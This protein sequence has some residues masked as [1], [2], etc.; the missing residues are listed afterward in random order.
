VA[1][2]LENEEAVRNHLS[3]FRHELS[4]RL[5]RIY[6]GF[7]QLKKEGYHVDA[8]AP[9][10]AI[11]LTVQIDLTGK[12]TD[13]GRLLETQADVTDYILNEAKLALVP[14]NAF[15]AGERSCW[16]RLS[17]GCCKKEDIDPMLGKLKEALER[18]T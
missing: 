15:G 17:V 18:L 2:F 9:Q 4:L 11:Y 12:K 3:H 16:Y 13:T 1:K 7:R 5:T 10:A 14:F 6:E 8:I